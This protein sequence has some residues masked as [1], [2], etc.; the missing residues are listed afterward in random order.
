[1]RFK[2]HML[3]DSRPI[4][5]H[6]KGVVM[7]NVLKVVKNPQRTFVI[8]T[9]DQT[10]LYV[11]VSKNQFPGPHQEE[12]CFPSC[13]WGGVAS[14]LRRNVFKRLS[15]HPHIRFMPDQV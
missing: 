10:C 6:L 4:V 5:G 2:D 13:V 11:N 8:S 12:I 3:V 7:L 1:M 15:F 14:G 9:T